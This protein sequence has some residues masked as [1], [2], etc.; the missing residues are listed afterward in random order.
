MFPQDLRHST[1][2]L[3]QVLFPV[4]GKEDGETALLG[5]RT[6]DVVGFGKGV[7]LPVIDI[8]RVPCYKYAVS[9]PTGTTANM[10]YISNSVRMETYMKKRMLTFILPMPLVLVHDDLA[11]LLGVLFGLA[12]ALSVDDLVGVPDPTG[13]EGRV[14]WSCWGGHGFDYEFIIEGRCGS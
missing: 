9:N 7:D 5:E 1:P 12:F 13:D 10:I 6:G 4:F 8:V 14:R 2:T 11:T 3:P